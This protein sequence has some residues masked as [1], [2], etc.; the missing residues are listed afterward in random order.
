[1]SEQL[2][3]LK[4]SIKKIKDK[5][6]GIYFFTLDTKGNPTAGVATIYEHVKKLRELGYNAQ[7]LHDKDDYKL[8]ED[9]N[10]IGLAEWLGDEY[11]ELPHISIE[12]QKLQVGPQDFVIIPEAFASVMKQTKDFPCKR[13]VFLQ[14]YEYIFEMLEIGEGWDQFNIRDVIT[15]NKNLTDYV[16]TI[17]RG[18]FTEEI[19]LAIP[20]YF[21]DSD[22]PK[23]PTISMSAR[24]K[25]ELLKIVKIFYQKYPHYRFVTFRD[26]SGLPR[27]D[28][29]DE[30]SK[31]FLSVWIDELSSFGTFPIESMKCNT[32]VIG[33]IPRMV[34]EW[35]GSVDENGNLNLNDNGIWTAN[36]NSI[37]DVIATMVGLYL[38]DALPENIMNGMEEYKNKYDVET[39]EKT[40]SEVYGRLF[41]RRIVE[42]EMMC[43]NLEEKEV[44]STEK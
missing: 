13:V 44:V 1:M 3:N 15:T 20:E 43:K 14:A 8:R 29:A 42:F 10:G 30:L 37:P 39:F 28:F 16:R 40:L 33:K 18:T 6:F 11:A 38:E 12:S 9:E 36:L 23:V 5:D 41:D 7:I 25:R 2:E 17:F 22:K 35:M 19:P 26:M 32:P 34:P 31:S 27:K 21:K 24:D 4:N